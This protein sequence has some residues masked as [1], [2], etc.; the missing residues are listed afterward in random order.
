M[1]NIASYMCFMYWAE[2]KK[3]TQILDTEVPIFILIWD[4]TVQYYATVKIKREYDFESHKNNVEY[5]M[6]IIWHRILPN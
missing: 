6:S 3:Y 4:N 5:S 1:L 2:K